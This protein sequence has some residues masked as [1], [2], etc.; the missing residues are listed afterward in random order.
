MPNILEVIGADK[1]LTTM[2]RTIKTAGLEAELS[3]AGPFTLFAPSEMAFGKI[4]GGETGVFLRPENRTKLSNIIRNHIVEG[5]IALTDFKDGQKLKTLNGN[6]LEVTAAKGLVFVSGSAI[7]GRNIEASNGIVYSVDK[8][9]M[10][11]VPAVKF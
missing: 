9:M 2:L 8:I 7:Q 5:K 4:A 3:D 11:S 10:P 6:E 1:N